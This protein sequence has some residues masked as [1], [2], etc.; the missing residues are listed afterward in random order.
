MVS[1]GRKAYLLFSNIKE[2]VGAYEDPTKG[3]L[4]WFFIVV[5]HC[6]TCFCYD[7]IITIIAIIIT[8]V[9]IITTIIITTTI[10][11]LDK[12]DPMKK[13]QL[14]DA[15]KRG[16]TS[17]LSNTD[18]ILDEPENSLEAVRIP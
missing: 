2:E 6:I 13:N 8:I 15:A 5:T 7:I 11:W 9:I 16:G 4:G 3:I 12:A 17:K 14:K 1:E 10:A 18:T